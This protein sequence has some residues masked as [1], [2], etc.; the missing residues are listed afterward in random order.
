MIRRTG[1]GS[2]TAK[3]DALAL[4]HGDDFHLAT[5]RF[6]KAAQRR[7]QMIVTALGAR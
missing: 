4:H 6:D 3:S 1:R 7:Q 2:D 5:E